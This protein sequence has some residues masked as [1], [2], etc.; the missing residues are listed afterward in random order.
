MEPTILDKLRDGVRLG[1][2]NRAWLGAVAIILSTGIGHAAALTP[3]DLILLDRLTFG[4]N[5]SSAAHLQAVG[6]ERWLNEQLHPAPNSPLPEAAHAQ[7]EKMAD[8]HKFP[9]DIAASFD[10]QAKSAR[11]VADPDQRKPRSRSISRR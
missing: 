3:H 8:V 4:V 1:C 5:A 6:V 11:E 7:I 10:A 2:R 9:I